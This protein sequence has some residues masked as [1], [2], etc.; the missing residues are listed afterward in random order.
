MSGL[1]LPVCEM[2]HREAEKILFPGAVTVDATVGKGN[3]TVFLAKAVGETGKV[4]GF[5]I[6]QQA[7]DFTEQRLSAAGLL[8][9]V[10]LFCL[11]HQYMADVIHED[12]D[13]V[14]FNLGYFPG[15]DHQLTTTADSTLVA[16]QSALSLLK[17][18]GVIFIALYW[19]H[20][21]G[22]TEKNQL[23]PLLKTLPAEE[24]CVSETTFP[25]RNRAPILI[26]IER[27]KLRYR[28]GN[29]SFKTKNDSENC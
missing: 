22:E 28:N 13:C 5:D 6:Q 20:S 9:R 19:G 18:N 25:N 16:F 23:L 26:E 21:E 11:G 1:I 14:I 17:P 4:Y 8:R 24:W 29:K 15:G 7:I 2:L 27:K 3:D 12:V 10:E